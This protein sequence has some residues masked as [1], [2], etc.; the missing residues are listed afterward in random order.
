MHTGMAGSPGS[1]RQPESPGTQVVYEKQND[2]SGRSGHQTTGS[3]SLSLS[4]LLSVCGLNRFSRAAKQM[5]R[6][7][8]TLDSNTHRPAVKKERQSYPV[9]K[10][11]PS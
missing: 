10:K 5:T 1:P 9:R 4:N 3:L 11:V 6:L 2:R 7:V 8:Q